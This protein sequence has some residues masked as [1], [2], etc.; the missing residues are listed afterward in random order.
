M[1][2]FE[3]IFIGVVYI[4]CVFGFFKFIEVSNKFESKFDTVFRKKRGDK[5]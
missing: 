4:G 5:E 1:Y 3:I 2:I